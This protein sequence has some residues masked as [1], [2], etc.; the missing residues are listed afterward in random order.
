MANA[1]KF[2]IQ[3]ETGG[4]TAVVYYGGKQIVQISH[5]EMSDLEYTIKKARQEARI[6]IGDRAHEV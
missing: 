6:A 5:R 3:L 4:T 2:E 1:G